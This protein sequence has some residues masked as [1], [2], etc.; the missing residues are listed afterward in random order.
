MVKSNLILNFQIHFGKG[1]EQF[2]LLE[3]DESKEYYEDIA[4]AIQGEW[5]KNSKNCDFEMNKKSLLFD[6]IN[7]VKLKDEKYCKDAVNRIIDETKRTFIRLSITFYVEF[8]ISI[9]EL[10][11]YDK[12]FNYKEDKD[13]LAEPIYNLILDCKK[14]IES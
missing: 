10:E 6:V 5:K 13:E 1:I 2:D 12:N 11:K 8:K 9:N 3:I 7:K 14:Y 4:E